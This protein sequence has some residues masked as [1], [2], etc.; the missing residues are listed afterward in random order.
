MFNPHNTPS[1]FINRTRRPPAATTASLAVRDL[2]GEPRDLRGE[3]R[4]LRGEPRD[5]LPDNNT[6]GLLRDKLSNAGDHCDTNGHV[7]NHDTNGVPSPSD[8]SGGPQP[9]NADCEIKE[10]P[11]TTSRDNTV[12]QPPATDQDVPGAGDPLGTTDYRS[13]AVSSHWAW[14]NIFHTVNTTDQEGEAISLWRHPSSGE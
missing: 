10:E 14:D 8:I 11:G 5:T 6:H 13:V 2:R 1:F 4:D 3:P 9:Q 7:F 12:T